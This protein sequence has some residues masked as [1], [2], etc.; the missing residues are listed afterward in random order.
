MS[1]CSTALPPACEKELV[2]LIALIPEADL[3]ALVATEP[4]FQK[5]GF[6]AGNIPAL[7]IR[8]QQLVCGGTGISD[9]LRRTIARR[10]RSHSLTGL[11]SP[12]AIAESR[13]ALATLLGDPVLLVALLLDARRDVREKAEAWMQQPQPFIAL[14]PADAAARLRG[15]FADLADLL[16]APPDDHHVAPT[17]EAWL[18]QKEK[19]ES[20]LRDLQTENRRLKSVDDRLT[21]TLQRLKA[22]EEKGADAARAAQTA[23]AALRQKTREWEAASAELARETSRREARLTA[24]VDLALANEFHGWLTN[25]R[26]VEDAATHPAAQTDLLAQAEAALRKQRE[27]DRHSGNRAVLGERRDCLAK[28]LQNVRSALR[29][30]LRRTPE[31]QTAESALAAEIR[32]LDD[33][34]EPDAPASPLEDAL[35]ARIHAAH[36]NELPRLRELPGIFASLQVLDS[37]AIA[38]LRNAFQKRLAAVEA[39]GIEPPPAQE[40]APLHPAADQLARALTGREAAILLVDGHNV[41]FGLP[42]RYNPVRGTSL[43]EAEKR[44]LLAND[45]VR[46]AAPNPAL[47]VWI[48]FDGPTHSDMQAAPN[49]RVTYSGGKGE[50]R[51]D[52]VLLDNIRFFKSASPDTPVILASNDQDLCIN[53]RRLG[54]RDLPVLDL[55]AFFM[56]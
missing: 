42:S 33:L 49:V 23:E 52:G 24:A 6:R 17:H 27:I 56:R 14:P 40:T 34:L 54:A 5:G 31:L 53:A 51:A 26:A 25:A 8:L 38:R 18:A 9:T 30:A 10:S 37:A 55:G 15:L 45:I 32:K 16:G 3:S 12:E 50:H 11:L 7:R 47:R 4:A 41:L 13:H 36:D 21:G 2:R 1:L 46:I 19:L 43:T 20:R 48:V 39:I 22:S 35:A 44:L 29:N 28:A